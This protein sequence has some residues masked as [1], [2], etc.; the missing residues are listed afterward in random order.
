MCPS[1]CCLWCFD[2]KWLSE[3]AIGHG[4][5]LGLVLG[6]GLLH[7]HFPTVSPRKREGG[8]SLAPW[9]VRWLRWPRAGAGVFENVREGGGA[10]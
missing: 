2:V 9:S 8:G 4:L 10:L 1:K 6:L 5:G 3:A 7:D